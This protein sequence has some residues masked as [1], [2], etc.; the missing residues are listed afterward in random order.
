MFE[1]IR[2]IFSISELRQKILLTLGLLAVYRIGWWI[3]LP[4]VDKDKLAAFWSAQDLTG[5]LGY[6]SMFSGT[7]LNNITI[8]GLGIMPYISAS[9]I[10][11]LLGTVWEPLGKLQ[12]EGE[13]GRKKINEY[14]R[15]ATV[16]ICI[17]QSFSYVL[18][19]RQYN[20]VNSSILANPTEDKIPMLWVLTSV[21]IMTAGTC[22]L[23]WLGEQI[24]EYGIGN[25]ISMLI[26][27]GIIANV[28]SALGDLAKN[29][30]RDGNAVLGGSSSQ[31][32]VEVL[33]ILVVLF[34]AVVV[35]VIY[36]TRGQRRIPMQSAKHVRGRR[37]YG[38][39]RQYLPLK[40]NQAGV[41][42]IIFASSLLMFPLFIF[43]YLGQATGSTW[44]NSLADQFQRGENFIYIFLYIALIFF[45]CYF[46]TAVTFNPKDMSDNLKNYGNFIPGYRPGKRTSEY[47][48]KVMIRITYVGAAF[49]A[50]IA[51]L[52]TLISSEMGVSFVVAGFFGGTSL[53]IAVS[54]IIDL[55]DKIDS[56]LIMRNYK[57]LLNKEK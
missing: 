19:V 33:I 49:L 51:I 12:K 56:H 28:P 8:F 30:F 22:F 17:I 26:M 45:F 47:L 34:I 41:M 5:V 48:E 39:N 21:L 9:I 13:S 38:G 50:V 7:N 18:L 6:V 14:T 25:G 2:V 44:L 35:G 53:L 40:V 31:L 16:A 15:Y 29:V 10:F 1:K 3:P 32:G 11:Q 46:W 4:I 27:A 36:M 42:P 43:K 24:D 23:M 37:V 20:C 57:G 54:V 55:I 52:P